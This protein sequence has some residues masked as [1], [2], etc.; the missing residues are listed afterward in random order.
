MVIYYTYIIYICI[1]IYTHTLISQ[2]KKLFHHTRM[3]LN[4][5][6]MYISIYP[7]IPSWMQFTMFL[8]PRA[9]LGMQGFIFGR[10]EYNFLQLRTDYRRKTYFVAFKFWDHL[11]GRLCPLI[12]NQRSQVWMW[13]KAREST[14]QI[15]RT[16]CHFY[17]HFLRDA[18][19]HLL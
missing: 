1:N 10:E 11:I 14:L 6:V 4:K 9:R 8:F 13:E 15:H 17:T 5:I 19:V 12:E 3:G 18:Y 16:I 2:N 7:Y